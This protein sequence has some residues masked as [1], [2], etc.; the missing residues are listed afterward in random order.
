M[1]FLFPKWHGKRVPPITERKSFQDL[2]LCEYRSD[3]LDVHVR[4]FMAGP[5]LYISASDLGPS[6]EKFWG[7]LDYEYYYSFSPAETEKLL[8]LIGGTKNP[9]AAL[10][11]EFGGL[12][13]CSRL[14]KFCEK[15]GIR[16]N[17]WS[18]V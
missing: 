15:E 1:E 11:R 14:E 7:D 12:S 16:Y 3:D 8:H 10:L 18:Y 9:R 13:G 17:F 5:G 4:A 2:V 6:V